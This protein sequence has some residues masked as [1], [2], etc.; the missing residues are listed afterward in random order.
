MLAAIMQRAR[1]VR[2]S[3]CRDDNNKNEEMILM[4]IGE[5]SYRIRIIL[6]ITKDNRISRKKNEN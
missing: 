1:R 5:T 6:L 4:I 2:V 3:T